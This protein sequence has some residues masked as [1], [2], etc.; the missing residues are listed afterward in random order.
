[1]IISGYDD[2]YAFTAPVGKFTP[3]GYGLYNMAGNVSEWCADWY[4]E[5]YYSHSPRK[6]PKGP[7][8]GFDKV[9]RGMCWW[10]ADEDW[11]DFVTLDYLIGV[12]RRFYY[13]PSYSDSLIGFRCA[14]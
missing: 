1:M 4:D 10:V 11:I 2:G 14:K 3:N 8:S 7:A 13:K 12:S 5:N 6:N 9:L